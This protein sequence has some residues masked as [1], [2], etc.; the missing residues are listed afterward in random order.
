MKNIMAIWVYIM[1]LPMCLIFF[2][3]WYITTSNLLFAVFILVLPIIYGYIIP[4]IATNIMKKWRFHGRMLLGNYYLHHGFKYASNIN[5]SFF[6]A[7]GSTYLLARPS[8]HN[9]VTIALCTACI[10]GLLIWVHD[11]CSIKLGMLEVKNTFNKNNMSAEEISF[12]YAPL[13]FFFIGL[14]FAS[15]SLYAYQQ[16]V[17]DNQET[18]PLFFYCLTAGLFFMTT[19]PSIVFGLLERRSQRINSDNI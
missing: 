10:H 8:F 11:T 6:I 17:I 14:T 18:W 1:P 2:F 15:S 3:Y 13:T 19:V 7:F 5:L 16:L 12:Q 4:G 9:Y